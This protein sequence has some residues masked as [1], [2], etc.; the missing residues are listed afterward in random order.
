MWEAMQQQAAKHRARREA[1]REEW[2][3][4]GQARREEWRRSRTGRAASWL[5]EP[6]LGPDAIP[7]VPFIA[8]EAAKAWERG[9]AV[10]VYQVEADLSTNPRQQ[11]A[12]NTAVNAIVALG[13]EL[14]NTST[15]SG[16]SLLMGN[17]LVFTFV[18]PPRLDGRKDG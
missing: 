13:W 4:Q 8:Q 18:R 2:A 3:E 14:Q 15:L 9:D 7:G 16:G 6:R 5:L 10:Y 17:A 11:A 1:Q 12:R